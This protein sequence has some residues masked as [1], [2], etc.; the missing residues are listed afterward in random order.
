MPVSLVAICPISDT[1][2]RVFVCYK[3]KIAACNLKRLIRAHC[4][5]APMPQHGLSE[6]APHRVRHSHA[7]ERREARHCPRRAVE[8][9]DRHRSACLG[10]RGQ[11][12]RFVVRSLPV[13][14]RESMNCP[15][16]TAYFSRGSCYQSL[17]YPSICQVERQTFS[18]YEYMYT[19]A[20]EP[21]RAQ[22]CTSSRRG[23]VARLGPSP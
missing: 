3:G 17:K 6:P 9:R 23:R 21:H 1:P 20:R 14:S 12:T 15:S 2:C 13:K 11:F 4:V 18:T 22:I 8:Q 7:D 16:G 10:R 5:R 19:S